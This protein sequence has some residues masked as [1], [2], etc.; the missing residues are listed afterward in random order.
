MVILVKRTAEEFK[1]EFAEFCESR[2][3][4]FKDFGNSFR[5]Q[6][7]EFEIFGREF[8][9]KYDI[10]FSFLAEKPISIYMINKDF[11]GVRTVRTGFEILGASEGEMVSVKVYKPGEKIEAVEIES[12]TFSPE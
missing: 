11:I 7:K 2:N 9:G 1:K 4:V 3:G 6:A 12:R 8:E 5:C 10:K